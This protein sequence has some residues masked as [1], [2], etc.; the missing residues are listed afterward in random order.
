MTAVVKPRCLRIRHSG[1]DI[2]SYIN[3]VQKS[4]RVKNLHSLFKLFRAHETLYNLVS[5]SLTSCDLK[6]PATWDNRPVP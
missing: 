5:T 6:L 2:V 3:K 4:D 1:C